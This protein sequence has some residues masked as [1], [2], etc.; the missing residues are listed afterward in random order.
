MNEKADISRALVVY[1]VAAALQVRHL[2]GSRVR[3]QHLEQG[4]TLPAIT[5]Q[6]TSADPQH[7]LGGAGGEAFSRVTFSCYGRTADEATQVA[8]Q[9][10]DV[11]DG[12][13]GPLGEGD[14]LVFVSDCTLENQYD[15]PEQPSPGG[16]HWRYKRVLDFA[17]SHSQ[18]LPSLAVEVE[19]SEP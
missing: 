18:P 17:V 19:D 1:R 6:L 15:R 16:A 7:H 4:E 12:W 11:L 8:G 13:S 5:Y 10:V 2:V 14:D 9:V 3:P